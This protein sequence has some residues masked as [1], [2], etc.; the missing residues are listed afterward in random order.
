[1]QRG[2]TRREPR[3]VKYRTVQEV[4]KM[5]ETK[6]VRKKKRLKT[7]DESLPAEEKRRKTNNYRITRSSL[8]EDKKREVMRGDQVIPTPDVSTSGRL[9][10]G[11]GNH[12]K[13]DNAYHIRRT[14]KS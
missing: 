6:E 4:N 13:R 5:P 8:S 9:E 3:P 12:F 10:Q 11:K 14:E 7:V 1:L 2:T